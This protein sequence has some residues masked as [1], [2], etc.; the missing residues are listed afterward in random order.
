MIH[1]NVSVN[2]NL[3]QKKNNTL[4][5]FSGLLSITGHK[6]RHF[7]N[8]EKYQGGGKEKKYKEYKTNSCNFNIIRTGKT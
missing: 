6:N 2:E 1:D 8:L 5:I 4:I 3:K 7:Y